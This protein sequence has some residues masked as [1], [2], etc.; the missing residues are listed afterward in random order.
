MTQRKS[1]TKLL[2]NIDGVIICS[3]GLLSRDLF[4]LKPK[5]PVFYSLGNM[6]G[7]MAIGLGVAMNTEKQVYVFIGDG[8][9]TMRLS[10]LATYLKYKP[11]NLHIIIFN[12]Q[13]FA[14][15]GG[16]PTNFEAIREYIPNSIKIRDVEIDEKKADRINISLD[17]IAKKF[18]ESLHIKER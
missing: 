12:N 14:S 5:Q 4:S 8:A 16:Q 17:K 1:L 9:F 7:V 6:G 3:L 13:S 10:F 18:Y 11:K 2:N 15:T